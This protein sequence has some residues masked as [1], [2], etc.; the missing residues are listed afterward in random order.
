[1]VPPFHSFRTYIVNRLQSL[2]NLKD[3]LEHVETNIP[4]RMEQEQTEEQ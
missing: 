3:E 4:D 2:Y 1:M